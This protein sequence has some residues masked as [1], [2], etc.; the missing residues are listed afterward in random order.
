MTIDLILIPYQRP[1]L[2]IESE[3]QPMCRDI[4]AGCLHNCVVWKELHV[5]QSV[6]NPPP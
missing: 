2:A 1:K 6:V 3:V 4:V 5:P